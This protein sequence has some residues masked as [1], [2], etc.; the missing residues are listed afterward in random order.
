MIDNY[1]IKILKNIAVLL[2]IKGENPFKVRAYSNAAE[3]ILQQNINIAECVENDSLKDIKGFGDALQKKITEYV[4]TGKISYYENLIKEFPETLIDVT[5]ISSIGPKKAKQL[6]DTLNITSLDELESAC[7]DGS[8]TSIKGFTPKSV[9]MILNSINHKK[10]AKGKHLQSNVINEA[11][12]I[13]KFLEQDENVKQVSISGSFR[14]FE[15]TIKN[16]VLV[17][18]CINSDN[19]IT[20]ILSN[21]YQINSSDNSIEFN[22]KS[23]L[24]LKVILTDNSKFGYILH[25]ST[26]NDEYNN[27]FLNHIIES[28]INLSDFD[29]SVEENVFQAANLQYIPP[30]LRESGKSIELAKANKIPELIND[31]D[32]KGVLHVHST[33]SDGKDSIRDMALSAKKLGFSYIGICDHSQTA[34]YTN[35]LKYDRILAQHEEI[36]KLNEEL[37][38]I[39][40]FK[41]IESDI[42]PDGS[43]DYPPNVIELF[44]FVV[45]SIHSGFNMKK[46]AMTKRIIYALMSPYTT[47]LG[48]PTG[49]LLLGRQSYE[50]DIREVID[51]A[52]EYKKIIEINS[53]PYRLDLSWENVIYAKENGLKIA[54]NPDSHNKDTIS[55]IFTG[56]KVARKGW[57]EKA[58]VINCLDLTEFTAKMLKNDFYI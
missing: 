38:G 8:L 16:L 37:N 53:N 52:V 44:D 35:G 58:D 13:T 34:V 27:A 14:R 46:D 4:Q 12:Q 48:H 50:V 24:P 25:E 43:L 1:L 51:V 47:I 11:L 9:E 40:I 36:D 41:G 42:L 32:L 15:E 6:F 45:A 56:V 28:C 21:Q 31:N 5:K 22:T 54:I 10:A 29:L 18:S 30:E 39:H 23:G 49:R 33:W 2:E 3:I 19:N 26:G 20:G 17:A 57:L 7:F 55:D